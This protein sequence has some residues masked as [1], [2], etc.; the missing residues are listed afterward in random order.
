VAVLFAF[1]AAAGFVHLPGGGGVAVATTPPASTSPTTHPSAS[2]SGA[3]TAST[4]PAQTP[5]PTSQPSAPTSPS[6]GPSSEPTNAAGEIEYTVKSGDSLFSIG[7]Q[8][9]VPWP[10]IAARNNL[11]D[12][13]V[14]HIGDVLIIPLGT[15]ASATPGGSPSATSFI[16]VVQTGDRLSAIALKFHVT[17]QAILDA[18]P[19]LTNPDTIFVGQQLV[20]PAAEP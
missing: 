4:T 13:Y 9:N 7:L 18:N 2:A 11:K 10:N 1:A 17:E 19:K 16:Y 6:L 12:P 3:P 15:A 5:S 8:F 20:I 14:I